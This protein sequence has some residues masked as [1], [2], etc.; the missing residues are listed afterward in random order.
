[1]LKTG[2]G[3]FLIL[4]GLV[5]FLYLGMAANWFKLPI[6]GMDWPV[7]SWLFS[8]FGAGDFSRVF[9]VGFSVVSIILFGVAGAGLLS[10]QAWWRTFLTLGVIVSSAMFL[11]LW[12]GKARNL[13]EQ[14]LVGILINIAMFFA[15]RV[16]D[17]LP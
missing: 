5:H 2:A 3:I 4:H 15:A 11:L 16:P 14:G 13:A 6:P 10:G 9:A 8:R 1:M 12:E 17:L 7:Q